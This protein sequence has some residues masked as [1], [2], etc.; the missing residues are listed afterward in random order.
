MCLGPPECYTRVIHMVLAM[1]RPFKHPRT[2]VYWFRRRVPTDLVERVGRKEVTRSL[3]TRDATEAKQRYAE[4]LSEY[5]VQW[6]NLRAGP[7]ALTER[8]AHAVATRIFRN[9]LSI[10][11]DNPSDQLWW[12]P[13]LFDRLWSAP[14]PEQEPTADEPGERPIG[15]VLVSSMRRYC[16]GLADEALADY[17]FSNDDFSRFV[18]AK[19]IAAALQRASLILRR[20]SLGLFT[21]GD[22][23]P[24]PVASIPE[25]GQPIRTAPDGAPRG[26]PAEGSPTLMSLLE[27]WWQEAQAAGRKHRLATPSPKTG[28]VVSAKTVKDSD[29]S[30]LKAVFG[31][32]LMNG[33]VAENPASAITVRLGKRPRLRAKGFT[34][35]EAKA[36]LKAALDHEPGKESP[37]TAAAKRWVPWL[38]AFTGARVGDGPAPKRGRD[39]A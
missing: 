34:D 21:P 4:V 28:K 2:G 25:P 9:W 12:H 10:Y 32:G 18:M 3:G 39:P 37:R 26:N 24:D 27:G 16:L 33:K 19:A 7:R 36:I 17:G 11:R 6:T 20:E 31:W 29:L 23:P 35:D 13:E 5:E 38:C 14:L 30:A 22:A 1:S 15:N 8:E